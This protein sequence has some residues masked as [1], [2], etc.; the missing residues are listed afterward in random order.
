[1]IILALVA[2]LVGVSASALVLAVRERRQSSALRD[3]VLA[4]SDETVVI[5]GHGPATTIG[6]ERQSNPFIMH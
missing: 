5:P 4:L 6:E 1:L 2:F 3:R